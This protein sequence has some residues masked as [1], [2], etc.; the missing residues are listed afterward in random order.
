EADGV[1][2]VDDRGA[3]PDRRPADLGDELG[4][5]T[6]R[7]LARELDLVDALTGVAH[8][9]VGVLNDLGGL[10]LELLLHV[11][12]ARREEDVAA[13]APRVAER[14]CSGLDVLLAG[15]A[16]RCDGGTFGRAGNG[17]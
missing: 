2:K 12:G 3:G 11:D 15:A 6:G 5:G 14:L 1:G 13:G 17:P 9:P 4:V 8:R 7:V 16:E 10:E